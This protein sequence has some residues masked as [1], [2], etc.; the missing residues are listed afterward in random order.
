MVNI[1]L[2][3]YRAISYVT[4]ELPGTVQKSSDLSPRRSPRAQSLRAFKST[5]GFYNAS[6]FSAHSAV[7]LKYILISLE[8]STVPGYPTNQRLKFA[9]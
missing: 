4:L 7:K 1:N 3:S 2:Y 9:L 6:A 8:N 5:L